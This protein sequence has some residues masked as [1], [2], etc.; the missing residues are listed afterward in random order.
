MWLCDYQESIFIDVVKMLFVLKICYLLMQFWIGKILMV[1]VVVE[2]YGVKWVL[3]LIKKKVISSVK[4][5]YDN[6]N[7][8]FKFICINYEQVYNLL[9]SYEFDLVI[10]DEV[11]GLG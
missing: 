6:F 11:Y 7:L 9:L 3:F 5:D 2:K 8:L 10:F 4:F 1:L